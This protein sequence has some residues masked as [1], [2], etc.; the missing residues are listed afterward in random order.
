M[1]S[2]VSV[3]KARPGDRIAVLSPSFAAPSIPAAVHDQ[4]MRRLA[5]GTG[6][7][8]I[9]FPTTR[10][11]VATTEARAADINAAFAD[12]RIRAVI[13]T[14]GGDDEVT[15]VPHV[16]TAI[17]RNDPKPFFGYS[18]N[19]NLHHLLWG[20][21]LYLFVGPGRGLVAGPGMADFPCHE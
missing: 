15:V 19:T 2:F 1:K 3:P 16:D 20:V 17:V 11:L 6:L 12:P 4:A 13:A 8:P 5:E 9:E 10:Q 18:D 14:T 21:P 7:V